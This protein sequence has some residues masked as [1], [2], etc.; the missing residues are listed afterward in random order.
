VYTCVLRGHQ[1]A[2]LGPASVYFHNMQE[3]GLMLLLVCCLQNVQVVG[4][5]QQ[6]LAEE[7]SGSGI[8]PD[9]FVKVV[10][11]QPARGP[12]TAPAA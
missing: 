2:K 1:Y 11:I 6:Q 9:G 7:K 12:R 4:D 3:V 8:L 5:A 10:R